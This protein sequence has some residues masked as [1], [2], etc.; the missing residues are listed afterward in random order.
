MAGMQRGTIV[1]HVL[2][3]LVTYNILEGG[4][5]RLPLILRVLRR[6]Q[7]DVVAIQE[8][9]DLPA[10]EWLAAQLNTQL[11]YGEANCPSALAWLSRLPIRRAENYRL[12]QLA[13]TLLEIEIDWAGCELRLFATHLADRRQDAGAYPRV[14]EMHAIQGVLGEERSM[15]VGDL[16]AVAPGDSVDDPPGEP[17]FGD[18]LSDAP[19][20]VIRALQ[21]HGYTDCFRKLHPRTRGYTYDA[22]RKLFLRLDYV[23]A[24]PDMA[25]QL[26]DCH[27]VAAAGA[28]DHLPVLAMFSE[29]PAPGTV[30]SAHGHRRDPFE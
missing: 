9:H 19:R 21:H 4:G 3:R 2:L 22:A 29:E 8:A 5:S 17:R 7:P 12:P 1:G 20:E 10:V 13:K 6:L 11:V 26:E 25:D 14:Q 30:R 27:V 23:F 18:A 24:S 16:N 28:S 15:L